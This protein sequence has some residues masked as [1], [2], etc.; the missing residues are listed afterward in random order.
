LPV[1][2]TRVGRFHLPHQKHLAFAARNCTG[3]IGLRSEKEAS[4]FCGAKFL[5]SSRYSSEPFRRGGGFQQ[6]FSLDIAFAR[7]SRSSFKVATSKHQRSASGNKD[8][9]NRIP[10]QVLRTPMVGEAL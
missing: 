2:L 9:P 3:G 8:I 5:D 4:R 10:Y 7:R 1:A 6:F